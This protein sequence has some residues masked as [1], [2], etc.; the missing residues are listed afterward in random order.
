MNKY[1]DIW[2]WPTQLM[3]AIYKHQIEVLNF[4]KGPDTLVTEAQLMLYQSGDNDVHVVAFSDKLSEQ[5]EMDKLKKF[6]QFH[7]NSEHMS[8]HYKFWILEDPVIAK[9]LGID[10]SRPTGDIY[11]VRE[12]NPVFNSDVGTADVFGFKYSSRRIITAEEVQANPDDAIKLLQELSFNAPMIAHDELKFRKLLLGLPT[13]LIYCDPDIHGRET[14]DRVLKAVSEARKK[15]PL[16]V[17]YSNEKGE[18]DIPEVMFVVSTTNK[19]PPIGIL[20]KDTP[21]ALFIKMGPGSQ[22]DILKE[23][24]PALEKVE[25]LPLAEFKEKA[26]NAEKEFS[27]A[28]GDDEA[29]TNEK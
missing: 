21:Q 15:M 29:T 16:I 8:G 18:N 4:F 28:P 14:Y 9:T 20:K 13:L 12:A 27:A 5:S 24:L 17:N 7:N 10:T 25:G 6:R 3:D 1:N 2:F 26:K 23:Y 19:L 22:V 11:A